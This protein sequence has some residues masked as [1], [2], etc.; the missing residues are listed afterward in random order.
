VHNHKLSVAVLGAS[1]GGL[2]LAG[3]LS[4][5][6]HFV[7][8]WNR[9]A[10]RVAAVA[11]KR[12][13]DLASPG[14]VANRVPIA[15][16]T[17]NIAAALADVRVVLVAV[18]ACAHADIARQCAAHLR[19]GQTVLLLPGRTGGVLEFR[20]VL[21]DAGCRAC[22]LLGEA[23]TFPFAARCVEPGSAV[24]YGAKKEVLAAA[25]PANQTPELLAA[26]R[27]FLPMLRP[28][29]SALHTGLANLG[30]ILHPVITL[31]NAE[32]IE[33]GE[34]FD[35]YREGVTASVAA[36]LAA[37]DAERLRV[38]RA[39]AVPACSLRDWIARA[40]DHH[41]ETIHAAV[42]GNPAYVGIKAPATLVH[43]YLLED[44]PT[45]LIPL[46]ELGKA[47]R[48]NLP[49]LTALVDQSR[50]LL[51]RHRW[52]RQRGLDVLGLDGL[53]AQSIRVYIEQ[54]RLPAIKRTAWPTPIS[55]GQF[56]SGL[57]LNPLV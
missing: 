50:F 39:Y 19:H 42:R 36:V 25:L 31:L 28:A 18:P 5:Q 17:S 27:P 34:S 38:A 40:Y 15:L 32:R 51:G 43:R 35:F 49:V 24:I 37:A 4:Q 55:L 3:Y 6:G 13:I 2:A 41:A 33:R 30:A 47:A 8:L 44:V 52:Q 11:Q 48:L 12:G 9:S 26:C 21:R 23:N 20:R 10:E 7:A 16:A 14:S 46:L 53:S 22:V 57:E 56:A 45:G 54:G 1:H 29:R